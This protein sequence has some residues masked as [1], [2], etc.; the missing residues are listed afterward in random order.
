MKKLVRNPFTDLD[1]VFYDI[2][3]GLGGDFFVEL[4]DIEST[5]TLLLF[6]HLLFNLYDN[7]WK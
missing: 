7:V 3:E 4:M 1:L 6:T 5:Y 2:L